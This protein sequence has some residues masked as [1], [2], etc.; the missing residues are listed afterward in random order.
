M[1]DNKYMK[2]FLISI[3]LKRSIVLTIYPVIVKEQNLF[4]AYITYVFRLTSGL[5][6]ETRS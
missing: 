6:Y 5:A 2:N 4:N 3:F 1:R